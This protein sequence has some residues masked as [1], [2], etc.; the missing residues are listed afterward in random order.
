MADK[1]N[2]ITYNIQ[3]NTDSGRISIDGLTKGFVDADKAV[4]KL[5]NDLSKNTKGIDKFTGRLDGAS[6]A[7]GASTSAT[8]ELGRV[9]SDM[10]YGI[11][12][13]ANNLQQLASNLFFMS[14]KTDGVTGKMLGFK[15]A[16]GSVLKG[17]V[18]PAGILIAFQGLIALWDY[19]SAG[20]EKAK[21][22]T[23][24]LNDEMERSAKLLAQIDSVMGTL[25]NVGDSINFEA[26]D[27]LIA[28]VKELDAKGV[29]RILE[30]DIKGI[31]N[32]FEKLP[33]EE[34][35][36]EGIR[37]L[38]QE[39]KTLT[40]KLLEEKKIKN[41]LNE[42]NKEHLRLSKVRDS[43]ARDKVA[44]DIVRK[45]KELFAVQKVIIDTEELFKKQKEKDKEDRPE[46]EYFNIKGIK[47]GQGKV[48]S[49]I[50]KLNDK[51]LLASLKDKKSRL[52]VQRDFHIARLAA[53]HGDNSEIVETYKKY[54][55]QLID[56][57]EQGE[58]ELLAKEGAKGMGGAP[59]DKNK[60][61][62]DILS[63]RLEKLQEFAN[64]FN[65]I[66]SFATSFMDS[67]YQRQSTIEQNKT[68]SLNNELRERLNNE[69]LS[70]EERKNIQLKIARNDENL[71]KRQEAIEKKRFKLNK[72]ANIANALVSTYAGASKAYYNTLADPK[73][74][75]APQQALL[76]AKIN[77]GIATALGLANVAMIARQKFQSSAGAS[78]TAG[79]LGGG[80]SGGEGESREFN[81]NLAGSTQSNQLTQSIASQL[82]QPIQTYVVSSEMTSQQQLD[83]NIANT[84]TIG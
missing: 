52:I 61:A 31:T 34:Q 13:V 65:E 42:L 62:L 39:Q 7:A 24:E 72:A 74:V 33:K 78:P 28:G 21:E 82:S 67:E 2:N 76:R 50:I 15:G 11:R 66:S 79:A 25:N 19:L 60:D 32:A 1:T 37:S 43:A 30:R 4:L 58:L 63:A 5:Q 59:R 81:F 47:E 70:A 14:K 57:A 75:L 44:E 83:L 45:Q 69:N 46:V 35:N 71:R 17:L 10:P 3:V 9:L 49:E 27:S 40:N 53:I 51:M 20:T 6:K 12:G 54:Y 77:A 48:L 8:L 38:V 29:L 22:E 16:V 64:K 80:S 73:N 56:T 26:V 68:N 84:A 23:S 41:E 36:I 55:R 18:G